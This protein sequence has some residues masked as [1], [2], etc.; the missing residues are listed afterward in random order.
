M[1]FSLQVATI[2]S[3]VAPSS[4]SSSS[5]HLFSF[6]ISC[7]QNNV[8]PEYLL[9]VIPPALNILP[10]LQT[11]SLLQTSQSLEQTWLAPSPPSLLPSSSTTL[12]LQHNVRS[13]RNPPSIG[14]TLDT[15]FADPTNASLND[16]STE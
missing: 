14:S 6:N 8:K 10:A 13:S 12:D 11:P 9:V 15:A 7:L 5:L 1:R 3:I 16:F 2:L 4:S